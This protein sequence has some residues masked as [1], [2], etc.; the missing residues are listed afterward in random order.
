MLFRSAEGMFRVHRSAVRE[1]AIFDLEMEHLHGRSW[2]YLGHESQV[3]EPGDYVTAEIA[4]RSLIMVR[5]TDKSVRVLMNRC[6]HKG[7][8][9]V[10]E[11]SGNT[12]RGFRCLILTIS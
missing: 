10:T 11:R 8:K 5:H 2:I 9:V 12:G 4:G 7:A 6:A 1:K 3:R